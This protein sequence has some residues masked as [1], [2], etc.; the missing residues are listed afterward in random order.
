MQ[1]VKNLRMFQFFA[2]HLGVVGFVHFFLTIQEK[3]N[4]Q[5]EQQLFHDCYRIAHFLVAHPTEPRP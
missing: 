2:T 3:G 1:G 5:S 4:R